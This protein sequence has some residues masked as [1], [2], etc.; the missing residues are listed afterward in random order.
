MLFCWG[1]NPK[2]RTKSDLDRLGFEE[3]FRSRY[4]I[5]GG[6]E[7]KGLVM[8]PAEMVLLQDQEPDGPTSS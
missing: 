3:S 1:D 6:E 2:E 4:L 5:I 7:N 8:G